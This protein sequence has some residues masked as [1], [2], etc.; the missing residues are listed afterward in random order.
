MTSTTTKVRWTCPTGKHPGVLASTRP[1]KDSIVRY[2]LPCSMETG[3]L[4]QRIAP[5]LERKRTAAA[6][7]AAAKAKAKRAREAAA[8]ARRLAAENER[9]IVDGLDL[10]VEM[11]RLLKLKAF[12]GKTGRLYRRPPTLVVSRRTSSPRAYVGLAEPWRNQ[13]TIVSYPGLDS[14]SVRETLVHELTHIVLGGCRDGSGKNQWH[15]PQFRQTL[16]A[17]FKEAYKVLPV[18]LSNFHAYGGG[19][20]KALRRRE[21]GEAS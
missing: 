10:R 8:K 21:Q 20:A 3:K 1:A 15:G 18:G 7:S 11:K 12:G 14:A 2:C 6:S 9:Y 4:T 16:T 13:I 17:A 5:A 19:Y